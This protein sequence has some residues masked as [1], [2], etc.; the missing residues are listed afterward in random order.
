MTA[1]TSIRRRRPIWRRCGRGAR[2]SSNRRPAGWPAVNS[3]GAARGHRGPVAALAQ[4]LSGGDLAGLRCL[5]PRARPASRSTRCAFSPIVPAGRWAMPW[6]AAGPP[7]RLRHPHLRPHLAPES[8]RLRDGAGGDG[9]SDA[10]GRRARAGRSTIS[11]SAR[12]R[13]RTTRPPP[14]W[15]GSSRVRTTRSPSRSSPPPISSR[16]AGAASAPIS[17]WSCSRRRRTTFWSTREE[18]GRQARRPRSLPTTSPG[19]SWEW[20]PTAMPDT[21]SFLPASR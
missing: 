13:P 18:A 3:A 12:R 17:S 16:S 14:P 9:R 2:T 19:P 6:P 21:F 5:L 11:S 1:C 7:R 4:V 20:R 8:G 10:G 15:T